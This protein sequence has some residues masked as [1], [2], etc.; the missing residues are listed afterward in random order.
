MNRKR[1]EQEPVPRNETVRRQIMDVLE[2]GT[3]SAK[4]LSAEVKAAEKEVYGHLDHIRK[5]L[6]KAGRKFVIT[7]PE[8][9]KCGFQFTKMDRLRKPGKCPNCR[10]EAI[11]EPLFTIQ[12]E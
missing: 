10:G 7:L 1:K 2:T 8:C 12:K 6:N 11:H 5:T 4:D 3:F 9:R